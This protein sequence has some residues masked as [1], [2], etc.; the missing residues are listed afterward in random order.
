MNYVD[1]R[2][3]VCAALD[4]M[5]DRDSNSFLKYVGKLEYFENFRDMHT[6]IHGGRSPC[7]FEWNY[8]VQIVLFQSY[9][10]LR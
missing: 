1:L 10:L 2:K 9:I 3:A 8:W 5:R 6:Y 4:G 7:I